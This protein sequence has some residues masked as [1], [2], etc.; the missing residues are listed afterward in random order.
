MNDKAI[1]AIA[2]VLMAVLAVGEISIYA[3]V[4]YGYDSEITIGEHSIEYSV[5]SSN[6]EEYSIIALDNGDTDPIAEL[7]ILYDGNAIYDR[8]RR[9]LSLRGF[10]NVVMSNPDNILEKMTEPEGKA[11]LVAYGPFPEEIYSGNETDPL[12]LWLQGGGSVYWFGYVPEGGYGSD[13]YLSNLGLSEDDFCTAGEFGEYDDYSV[14]PANPF[15]NY[16]NLR[17]SIVMNGLR[18]D[19]GTPLAYVSESGFSS[20]TSMKVFNGTMVIFGGGNSYENSMDCA[21]IIASGITHDSI[22]VGYESGFVRNTKTGILQYDGTVTSTD[23]ISV[24]VFMGGY[25][26]VYG[27]RYEKGL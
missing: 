14:E 13:D 15:C 19:A 25:Y 1:I 7:I 24:Y 6:N 9:E 22:V 17:N 21:Q 8:I 2:T 16:L 18:A 5:S 20:I 4:P 10:D 23:N 26:I 27:E 12:I 11:L 3:V